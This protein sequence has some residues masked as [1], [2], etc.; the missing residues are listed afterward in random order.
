L[1]YLRA[2]P[3]LPRLILLDLQMPV[4]DGWQFLQERAGDPRMADIPVMVLTAESGVDRRSLGVAEC[5]A[6][7]VDVAALLDRIGHFG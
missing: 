2:S 4:M 7:P 3:Q 6:K 5:L 1:D